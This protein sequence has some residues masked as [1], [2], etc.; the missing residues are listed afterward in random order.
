MIKYECV[1]VFGCVP[2]CVW[3]QASQLYYNSEAWASPLFPIRFMFSHHS[4][5]CSMIA[6]KGQYNQTWC[7][8]DVTSVFKAN[9]APGIH[10]PKPICARYKCVCGCVWV[11]PACG[12]ELE[13]QSKPE[14]SR[15]ILHP[16]LRIGD[17][18]PCALSPS[19][20]NH[21]NGKVTGVNWFEPQMKRHRFVV[22][23]GNQEQPR[24]DSWPL[25]SEPEKK[26]T[27][28]LS[29]ICQHRSCVRPWNL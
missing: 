3:P 20:T 23:H 9:T 6:L 11:Q 5:P 24:P 19:L 2:V 29:E 8:T 18:C 15:V 16:E 17:L 26:S 12:V 22:K 21:L 1:C 28:P 4:C 25:W 13:I 7:V 10:T 27:W 14:N